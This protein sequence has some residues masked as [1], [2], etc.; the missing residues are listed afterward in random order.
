M[1]SDDGE[2]SVL[3]CDE[4]RWNVF[5]CGFF[6][7][8]IGNRCYTAVFQRRQQAS[9]RFRAQLE[10]VTCSLILGA[11]GLA[12]GH[13]CYRWYGL[14]LR[15][16]SSCINISGNTGAG[17]SVEPMLGVWGNSYRYGIRLS[18]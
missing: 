2:V 17:A 18:G 15:R 12:Y 11:G 1:H 9:R 6:L 7:K 5:N 8:E 14:I 13:R 16:G 3:I 4:V 10:R